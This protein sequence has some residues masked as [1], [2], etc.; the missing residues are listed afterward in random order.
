MLPVLILGLVLAIAIPTIGYWIHRSQVKRVKA[1]VQR[2]ARLADDYRHAHDSC[3]TLD[4]LLVSKRG[5]LEEKDPW[6]HR[7]VLLPAPTDCLVASL[8]PDGKPG[9][10]LSPSTAADLAAD[11]D[12]VFVN[13]R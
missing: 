9:R 3:P 8:G 12:V 5:L 13:G 6:G 7:Y 2:I 10:F 11:D 4:I 1:D